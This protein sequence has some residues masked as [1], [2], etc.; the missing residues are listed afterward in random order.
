MHV[1]G[2]PKREIRIN[3]SVQSI[4]LLPTILDIASLPPHPNAQGQ[5]LYPLIKRHKNFFNRFLWKV[6]EAFQ[7]NSKISFAEYADCNF[8]VIANGYQLIIDWSFAFV[9]A[10]LVPPSTGFD[11]NLGV[12]F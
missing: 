3:G 7:R 2:F 8:S 11:C 1:P 5:S 6:L 9:D 4:D 10:Q 12:I